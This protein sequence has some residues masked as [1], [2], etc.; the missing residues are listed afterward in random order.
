MTCF[1][2]GTRIVVCSPRYIEGR[3]G[4]IFCILRLHNLSVSRRARMLR[5]GSGMSVSVICT[6]M[7]SGDS[8]R[9]RWR[10]GCRWSTMLSRCVTL[11]LPP[12]R[13]GVPSQLQQHT[14]PRISLSWCTVTCAVQSRQ[15]HRQATAISC[16]SSMTPPVLCGL[17]C[18]HQ[19]TQRQKQSRR[20]RWQQRWKAGAS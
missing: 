16:C 20:S 19:R 2:F 9:R 1:A 12:S 14:V 13:G 11:A 4:C 10:A 18:C 17:C 15:R 8:A 3:I 5:H 7:H 6:S